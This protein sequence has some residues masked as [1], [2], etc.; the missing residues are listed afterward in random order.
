[1]KSTIR[2]I[3]KEENILNEFFDPNA[4]KSFTSFVDGFNLKEA[5]KKLLLNV[6]EQILKSVEIV[7]E[8][9]GTF[10]H[11]NDIPL[12]YGLSVSHYH[13]K[14]PNEKYMEFRKLFE[15]DILRAL[16]KY[17]KTYLEIDDSILPMISLYGILEGLYRKYFLTKKV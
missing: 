17:F 8:R 5:E 9:G 1:M 14:N 4:L 6:V 11:I 7:K 13:T 16:I 12:I 3:L 15:H 10:I 2:R